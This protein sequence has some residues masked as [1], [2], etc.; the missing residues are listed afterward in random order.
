MAGLK[1]RVEDLVEQ[2]R[3]LEASG[4][5]SEEARQRDNNRHD[6]EL[7]DKDAQLTSLRWKLK[8][9]QRAK[10]QVICE[11]RKW[12]RK[13]EDLESLQQQGPEEP[14]R[15]MKGR[16]RWAP[17]KS[18]GIAKRERGHSTKKFTA[19]AQVATINAAW[20]AKMVELRNQ[21][22]DY[23]A[24]QADQI[25]NLNA[26]VASL[27]TENKNLREQS[28][29]ISGNSEMLTQQHLFA[30]ENEIM[31]VAQRKH[32]EIVSGLEQ[33]HREE[34]T[35]AKN[36]HEE[37]VRNL[38]MEFEEGKNTLAV[39]QLQQQSDTSAAAHLLS[40]LRKSNAEMAEDVQTQREEQERLQ[41]SN[42]E[43]HSQLRAHEEAQERWIVRSRQLQVQIAG[44]SSENNHLKSQLESQT[45]QHEDVTRRF[46]IEKDYFVDEVASLGGELL[47]LK[48]DLAAANRKLAVAK[49][50]LAEEIGRAHV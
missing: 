35:A 7:R 37:I 11:S 40:T 46:G 2:L 15:G 22:R 1:K 28:G 26:A 27:S 45:S 34:L 20:E 4:R 8:E 47:T 3:G 14:V 42:A 25:Q 50:D 49:R 12:R 18:Y 36:D 33:T 17:A 23:V 21:A 24:C 30:V 5:F 43:A 29:N 41:L 6:G 16:P 39:Q 19:V 10:D 13:F 9:S 48:R 38:K 31:M 44:L 32:E